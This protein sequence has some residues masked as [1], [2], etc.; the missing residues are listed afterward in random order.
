MQ[1]EV[2]EHTYTHTHIWYTSMLTYNLI[3]VYGPSNNN[4]TY[5]RERAMKVK[6]KEVRCC[7]TLLTCTNWDLPDD[8]DA[9]V[10]SVTQRITD[11]TNKFVPSIYESHYD[12]VF[13]IVESPMPTALVTQRNC[14]KKQD[15]VAYAALCKK[16]RRVY[17]RAFSR[18]QVRIKEKLA[19]APAPRPGSK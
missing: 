19:K 12:K 14:L 10:E 6:E 17:S 4:N 16:A 7:Q 2:N 8:I 18:H 3:T 9:A 15:R 5:S 1:G 13:S 11:V